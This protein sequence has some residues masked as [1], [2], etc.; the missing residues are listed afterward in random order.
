MGETSF[1][2][3]FIVFYLNVISFIEAGTDK[4]D[5]LNA[6]LEEKNICN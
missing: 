4:N 5:L 3:L 1:V 2:C 6:I